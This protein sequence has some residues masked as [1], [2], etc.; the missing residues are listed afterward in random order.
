MEQ[1][2]YERYTNY[3][4]RLTAKT[5]NKEISWRKNSKVS[6][7]LESKD[8]KGNNAIISIQ[9]IGP[10][11]IVAYDGKLPFGKDSEPNYI[12]QIT[13]KES[14]IVVHLATE[15]L[16]KEYLYLLE[17]IPRLYSVVERSFDIR[18]ADFFESI[19]SKL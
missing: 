16:G 6:F 15:D 17:S 10:P 8:E 2:V 7:Y 4:A 14:E 13:N 19:M 12:F 3:I 5:E 9:K 1:N 18:G 11:G